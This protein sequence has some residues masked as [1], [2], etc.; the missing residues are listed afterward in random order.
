[1]MRAP[2]FLLPITYGVVRRALNEQTVLRRVGSEGR[3]AYRRGETRVPARG[4][5]FQGPAGA[6]VAGLSR[7]IAPTGGSRAQHR[8]LRR[9]VRHLARRCSSGLPAAGT[10]FRLGPALSAGAC[11]AAGVRTVRPRPGLRAVPSDAG[12]RLSGAYAC[13][14]CFAPGIRTI[15][16]I[17]RS[18]PARHGACCRRY[19]A[20][21][22]GRSCCGGAQ[23]GR[24]LRRFE[25]GARSVAQCKAG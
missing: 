16:T 2:L 18:S 25:G 15:C 1:M 6:F 11:R 19:P 7:W 5:P 22:S 20:G 12:I 10:L 13:I 3:H 23:A 24:L 8:Q 14:R 9:R 4:V 17:P 21:P